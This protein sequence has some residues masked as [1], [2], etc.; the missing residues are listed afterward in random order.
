MADEVKKETFVSTATIYKGGSV[1]G[2]APKTEVE[3]H[4]DHAEQLRAA[5]LEHKIHEPAKDAK[6]AK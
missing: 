3:L 6:K 4:S 2:F 1:D 5:G